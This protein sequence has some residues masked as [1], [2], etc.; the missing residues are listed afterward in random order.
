MALE[1]RRKS[2]SHKTFFALTLT[3]LTFLVAAAI[4]STQVFADTTLSWGQIKDRCNKNKPSSDPDVNYVCDH[5]FE[6]TSVNH[7][8]NLSN[9]YGAIVST[10]S[11]ISIDKTSGTKKLSLTGYHFSC[12]ADNTWYATDM[13]LSQNACGNAFSLDTSKTLYEGDP[14]SKYS[15]GIGETRSDILSV[16]LA[17]LN[18]YRKNKKDNATSISCTI[19]I[20]STGSIKGDK[21]S[22]YR[23]H[24]VVF[25][26]TFPSVETATF[27]SNGISASSTQMSKSGD[28]FTG[29]GKSTSYKVT[30]THN[31]KRTNDTPESATSGYATKSHKDSV[32]YASSASASTNAMANNQSQ[33]IP[34]EYTVDV[35]NGSTVKYCFAIKFDSSANYE[36]GTRSSGNF[37][38]TDSACY[39][40]TNPSK[41][42]ATFSHNAI[43]AS[44]T[45][46]SKSGDTF[47]G[48]GKSTSYKVTVNYKVKRTNNTPINATS[49]YAYADSTENNDNKYPSTST[50]STGNLQNGGVK[51]IPVEYTIDI[52]NGVT[53]RQHCFYLRYDS[54]VTYIGTTSRDSADFA[55]KVKKCFYFT[56]PA[57]NTAHFSGAITAGSS[58]IALSSAS[59]GTATGT[60]LGNSFSI[61][62][63]Y[64][65]TRLASD[66]NPTTA[67]SNYAYNVSTIENDNQ[68]PST[69][70]AKLSTGGLKKG[71]KKDNTPSA[72]SFTLNIDANAIV[73]CFYLRYDSQ[74]IYYDAARDDASADFAGKTHICYTITNPHKTYTATFGTASST[75]V[76]DSHDKLIRTD[77]N[78]TGTI[79]H[80]TRITNRSDYANGRFD[81]STY[82][83]S[84][85][86]TATFTHVV[87]RTDA[88]PSD[89]INNAYVTSAKTSWQV[90]YSLNGGSWTKYDNGE[91]DLTDGAAKTITTQPKW[92]MN[93]ANAGKYIYYCQRL[94]YSASSTYKTKTPASGANTYETVLT[95]YGTTSYTTPACVTLKN[96]LWTEHQKGSNLVHD[97]NVS[98]NTTTINPTGARLINSTNSTAYE[99]TALISS[100]AFDHKLTRTDSGFSETQIGRSDFD[101]NISSAFFHPSI[102]GNCNYAVTTKMWGSER[103]KDL[104]SGVVTGTDLIYAKRS[105]EGVACNG[106]TKLNTGASGGLVN[107]Y[108]VQ[109]ASPNK[110]SSTSTWSSSANNGRTTT[111]FHATI[112]GYP[113]SGYP[114]RSD[115]SATSST[116]WQNYLLLAGQTKEFSQG[117][118]NTRSDWYVRYKNIVRCETY[119]SGYFIGSYPTKDQA[120]DCKYDRTEVVDTAPILD[121]PVYA[122]SS[123]T[124]YT[125]FRPYNYRITDIRPVASSD[126]TAYAGQSVESSFTISVSRYDTT[127]SYI[128]DPQS[129]N[130]YVIGYRIP[131]GYN[132]EDPYRSKITNATIGAAN[133]TNS[134]NPQTDICTNFYGTSN[135]IGFGGDGSRCSI[136]PS[137]PARPVAYDDKN[138]NNIQNTAYN[139]VY[140]DSSY[141]LSYKTNDIYVPADLAI[142]EKYCVAIAIAN[143]ST[144]SNGLANP[145]YYISKSTCSNIA[146]LP[147][148]NILSGSVKT[149][150]G[151]ETS[152]SSVRQND[153]TYRVYGSWADFAVIADKSIAKMASAASIAQ[154]VSD[155]GNLL[156]R[157]SH[158]TIA[159][160]QCNGATNIAALGDSKIVSNSTTLDKLRARYI[161]G[162][163]KATVIRKDALN[164]SDITA[165]SLNPTKFFSFQPL[166]VYSSGDLVINTD[167]ILEPNRAFS[168]NL[169]PQVILIA[170]RDVKIDQSVSHLDAWIVSGGTI[171]T[172]TS[173]ND[174]INLSANV[175]NRQLT[176]RGAVLGNKISFKRTYAGDANQNTANTPAEIIQYSPSTLLFS[177]HESQ[178]LWPETTYLHK[179]PV[180]F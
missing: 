116:N 39:N 54:S 131:A 92:T 49:Y 29:D 144:A 60:G 107:G 79:D 4:Y 106:T 87:A 75:S 148:V 157:T 126:L 1:G 100:F 102:H 36:S 11:T 109:L 68:Y 101:P 165:S 55:G 170:E 180:R 57:K 89:I 138:S 118:Y 136:L 169:A 120:K 52:A 122:D 150:G 24:T 66:G 51:T 56:N 166:V 61:S 43:S 113:S 31:I 119:T 18:T 38:G 112:N 82:P 12:E 81:D 143:Y 117:T 84:D 163:A 62:P 104:T 98:G 19:K 110:T 146:K 77:N 35:P 48:D 88:K 127:K 26:F 145:N 27:A 159:N 74:V 123:Y 96:P 177:A 83:S 13:S 115:R 10:N 168:A 63:T 99:T 15:W 95:D 140:Q 153:G 114:C 173:G 141:T 40:F 72:T 158:L 37:A 65:V 179:L 147:S 69:S 149:N 108:E 30:I 76:L 90:Q 167:I 42:V 94:A 86:Y 64:S 134:G 155:T 154:G 142:G 46:M 97:I 21:T 139:H 2:S 17:A 5:L 103:T 25:N 105:S 164:A 9:R 70:V 85:Q 8:K 73:R 47:T 44:S 41:D 111:C 93:A 175:C 133:V 32:S 71:E 3:F 121:T 128:T 152:T 151:I 78:T 137:Q 45:Q 14:P 28:T 156:C 130:A 50:A 162:N 7:C 33:S 161:E 59:G 34:V 174:V 58:N 135:R 80:S 91:T 129:P 171:D 23:D 22:S 178:R 6:G 20:N 53:N 67:S 16:D 160:S 125:I 176:I 132:A 172:C 124:T